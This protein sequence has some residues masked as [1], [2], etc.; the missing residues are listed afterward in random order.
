MRQKFTFS[1]LVFFMTAA[2]LLFA[3]EATITGTVTDASGSSLP[4]VNILVKG[5]NTGAATDFDGNYE[6]QAVQG[7]V[8]VFSFIGFANKEV[9]VEGTTVNVT[10]AEDANELDEVVVT[11]FGIKKSTKELGYSVSQVKTE[12]LDLAG[13]TSAVSALQGRVAGLSVA[14]TSGTAGGSVDILI[15]GVSSMNPSQNNQPLIIVDGVSINNDT[16]G[17]NLTPSAGTG[18]S[19]YSGNAQFG[20]SSRSSDINPDDIETYNVLKGTAATALYG[21]R[22]ANGVIVITTKKGKQGKAKINFSASTTFSKVTKTPEIQKLYREGYT[23]IP[24]MLYTPWTET[25]FTSVS[26]ST[27]FHTWGPLYSDDEYVKGDGT[28]V[29][30]SNDRYYDMYDLFDVGINNTMNFN[31]SGANEKIDY[32]LSLGN[33]ASDGTTPGNLYDKTTVRFNG[34]YQVTD[35]FKISSSVQ[36]TNSDTRQPAGGD[37]SVMSALAYFSTSYP[38][39]DYLN[40][41]GTQRNFTPWIDNPRYNAEVSGL[42]QDTNRWIGNINMNWAA[43][44]WMNVNYTAQVDNY[45]EMQNRFVAPELDLGSKVNGSLIEQTKNYF[46]LESN[47]IITFNK[48]WTEKFHSSFLVGN[49]ITDFRSDYLW[50]RGEGFNIPH[51]NNMSNTTNR[52][53]RNWRTQ[54]RLIGVFGEAKFDW[55]NKLFLS[56]SARN[57]WDSTLR[58]DNNSFF[59]PSVSLA[60]DISSIFGE[61]DFFSFGKL[62]GSY[63]EVGNGT[64]FGQTGLLGEYFYP[65]VDFPWGNTGG[66]A[67][68]INVGHAD[69]KPERTKGWEV[70]AD[71]RFFKNRLRFDYA[72]YLSNTF[73]AIFKVPLAYSTG[74]SRYTRNAGEYETKGQELMISGDVI[75]NDDFT[76][77]LVYNFSTNEGKVIDLPEDVSSMYFYG[78]GAPEIFLDLKE[79][80]KMGTLYGYSWEYKDGQRFID[81]DGYPNLEYDSDGDGLDNYSIIGNAMPDFNMSLGSNMK[82]RNFRFNF[83]VEWQEGGDKYSWARRTMI[84][85]GTSKVTELRNIDDYVLDGVMEDP[86]NPGTYIQNTIPTAYGL[87][88]SYYRS[89]NKFT[90]A[91]EV[92]L[93]D[94]SFVKLRNIGISYDFAGEF[95]DKL[96]IRTFSLNAS[97]SNILLWTEYDGFDPEGS[98][99]SAGSNIYGFAGRSLPLTE[100]YSFGVSI[101]F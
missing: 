96:N 11:A 98:A 37:K 48:D 58:L 42:T 43:A 93:Q 12:D 9:T 80:D 101:G 49:Q 75:K 47:L 15:R 67:A 7:D 90:G 84:R 36:Y 30:L 4:G 13:Q 53:A 55:D 39:N 20:L 61:G 89:W 29:D 50:A 14:P 3:Q 86:A 56:V 72:Y 5:T 66:L 34:G 91:A 8:L 44:E 54:Q 71:L 10:L 38:I 85:N 94:A 19:G 26:S 52:D 79:G 62:R 76:W 60:Y 35:Q 63:A 77:E 83:L 57:D 59:Y 100:N 92:N 31:I 65:G 70:G 1:L 51:Y 40:E 22:G 45:S 32:F 23:Q 21:I 88:E 74:L 95:M 64:I 24:E 2:Q 25:G 18:S 78:D 97:A 81:T 27:P 87:D 41:D 33:V 99:F 68:A 16:G 46:G 17:D 28:V 73:D 82:W 6:I 69:L